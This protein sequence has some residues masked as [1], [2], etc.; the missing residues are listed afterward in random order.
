[1]PASEG[2]AQPPPPPSTPAPPKQRGLFARPTTWIIAILAVL[3]LL[4][5]FVALGQSADNDELRAQ[6]ADLNEPVDINTIGEDAP[7][8]GKISDEGDVL[9]EFDDPGPRGEVAEVLNYQRDFAD[10]IEL[11]NEFIALPDD[12]L[13]R[14]RPSES[15]DD[16][17]PYYDPESGEINFQYEVVPALRA[18]LDEHIE[19]ESEE[20]AIAAAR[21]SLEFFAYHE[22]GHALIDYL[23]L[24]VTGREED[25]VDGLAMVLLIRTYEGTGGQGVALGTSD[26]FDAFAAA[27]EGAVGFEDYA[28]EHSLD[29]QR[30]VQIVC[31][32]YGSDAEEFGFLVEDEYITPERAERCTEEYNDLINA[33]DKLLESYWK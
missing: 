29:E 31:W 18:L 23:E 10:D 32:V 17:G 1:M 22:L 21:G 30:S 12:I 28:D 33:W 16:F 26:L 5:G 2:V 27:D 4:L 13:V 14:F 3:V 11:L 6:L 7:T 8:E 15:E 9:I 25:A 24:P 19:Y 20:D